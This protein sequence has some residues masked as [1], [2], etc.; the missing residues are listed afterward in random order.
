MSQPLVFVIESIIGGGKTTLLDSLKSYWESQGLSVV[1]VP[2]PVELWKEIGILDAF[3]ENPKEN[4]Y[5]FQTFTY[6]TRVEALQNAY[7]GNPNADIYI[8]ERSVYSDRYFF[9][10]MLIKDGTMTELEAKLYEKWWKLWKCV[11]PLFPSKFIYLKP[12]IDEC[13]LRLK[14]R[15]RKCEEGI[16]RDYQLRLQ[17]RHDD[18]FKDG[19]VTIGKRQIPTMILETDEDFREEETAR[20]I[21][22]QIHKI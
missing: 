8:L 12:S 15:N 16:P 17:E 3:Y 20:K 10:D 1:T 11:V 19:V 21:A 22:R 7:K 6:I 4:A 9:V 18:F 13:M 14:K 2:E 5:K